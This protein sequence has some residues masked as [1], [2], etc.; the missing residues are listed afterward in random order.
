MSYFNSS[1]GRFLGEWI[2][3][4]GLRLDWIDDVK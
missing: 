1:I 3:D 4:L 2:R